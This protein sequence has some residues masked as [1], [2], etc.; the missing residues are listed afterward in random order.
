MDS[1]VEIM[2]RLG[3]CFYGDDQSIS[4]SSGSTDDDRPL[5]E[6]FTLAF[7]VAHIYEIRTVDHTGFI[8]HCN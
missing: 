5:N 4:Q 2:G 7:R 3:L 8:F 1:E 6:M